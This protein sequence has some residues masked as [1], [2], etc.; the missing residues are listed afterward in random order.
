MGST[1][2]CQPQ[3]H[4]YPL[5]IRVMVMTHNLNCMVVSFSSAVLP[6]FLESYGNG[7]PDFRHIVQMLHVGCTCGSF[8]GNEL[9]LGVR[10]WWY[11]SSPSLC[12][13]WWLSEGE[14]ALDLLRVCSLL[15][16]QVWFYSSATFGVTSRVSVERAVG[17]AIE[18][19]L[20]CAQANPGHS[21]FSK[22]KFG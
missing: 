3:S 6:T 16:F 10:L 11:T 7:G 5:E 9:G 15:K 21:A 19:R 22:K 14:I 13:E 17:G 2:T 12:L 1:G 8:C 20:R 4:K 18:I